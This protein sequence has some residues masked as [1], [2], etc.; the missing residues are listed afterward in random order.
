MALDRLEEH[1]ELL[2]AELHA[3]HCGHYIASVY[4]EDGWRVVDEYREWTCEQWH[5][6]P[7]GI[8]SKA[9]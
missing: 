1:A 4:P 3:F 2:Y 7:K 5:A 9:D 8:E 6:R